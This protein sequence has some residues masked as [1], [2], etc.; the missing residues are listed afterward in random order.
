L[1]FSLIGH[2]LCSSCLSPSTKAVHILADGDNTSDHLAISVS[3]NVPV[4]NKFGHCRQGHSF[5]LKWERADIS[6]YQNT[7][8]SQLSHIDLPIN[9]LLC[10]NNCIGHNEILDKYYTD[11]LHCLST[12]SKLCITEVK[13]GIEKHWWTADLDDLKQPEA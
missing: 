7:V 12:S 1:H 4:D 11:I 10:Q 9:A 2:F 5:R 13:V 3:R 8:A 6:L